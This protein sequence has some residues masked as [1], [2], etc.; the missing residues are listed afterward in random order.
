M[1]NIS[2]NI[3]KMGIFYANPS[4]VQ[5]PFT[6]GIGQ[7]EISRSRIDQGIEA[8]RMAGIKRVF[9]GGFDDNSAHV[10]GSSVN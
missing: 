10:D 9:E 6:P 5:A 8:D 2:F 1:V 7:R 3:N 4:K